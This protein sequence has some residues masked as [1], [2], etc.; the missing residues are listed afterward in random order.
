MKQLEPGKLYRTGQQFWF[1]LFPTISDA[2]LVFRAEGRLKDSTTD[3][4]VALG[5]VVYWSR[6]INKSV[7]LLHPD[8]TV[9]VVD[10]VD[11]MVRVLRPDGE[12][13]WAH[14][15]AHDA[16]GWVEKTIPLTPG[17]ARANMQV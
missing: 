15:S 9:L 6:C 17:P 3:S 4:V 12:C 1:L 16:R 8:T 7:T 14:V 11:A 13:G 10:S 5:L 2:F